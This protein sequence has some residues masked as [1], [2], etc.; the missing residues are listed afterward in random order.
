LD[1]LPNGSKYNQDYF[2]ENLVPALNEVKIGNERQNGASALM[3]QMG[4]SIYHNGTKIAEKICFEGLG[5]APNSAYSRDIR[6]CHLSAFGTIEGIRND[7]HLQGPEEIFRAIQETWS[8]FPFKDFQTVFK[9]WTERVT[10]VIANNGEYRQS[11][12]CVE[13]DFM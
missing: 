5:R 13:S 10:W 6:P 3:K 11:E 1:D 8:H 7:R 2:I 12:N 4:N 9:S